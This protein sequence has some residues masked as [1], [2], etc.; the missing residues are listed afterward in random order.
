MLVLSQMPKH[1]WVGT[2]DEA[3]SLLAECMK[4]EYVA[5][6]TET[7]GLNKVKDR[8]VDWSVAFEG[9]R[10]AV[11]GKL[12]PVFK[13][14]FQSSIIKVFQN[15]KF[16]MHALANTGITVSDPIH[17]TL[18]MSRLENTERRDNDLKYLCSDGLFDKS[19]PRHIDYDSPFGGKIKSYRD[20]MSSIGA[21]K[22][23]EYASLDAIS[24][25]FVYE[26][27]RER[28]QEARA[29]SSESLWSFFLR[30]EVPFTRVL[31]NCERRG[32][33][34]DVGYLEEKSKDAV[35]KAKEIE[36]AF[37]QSAGRVINLSSPAQLR[38]FFFDIKGKKPLEYTSGG[39]SG[40]RQPSVNASTLKKW[41][42]MGDPD[43]TLLLEHRKLIKLNGTYLKGL[44]KL[45]DANFRIHTNLNQNGT[46][47][48]RLSS[49][50]P[51]LRHWRL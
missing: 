49:S 18:V 51:N 34:V 3:R 36:Y 45:A 14:L 30:D 33:M 48:G 42:E 19:D 15:S 32:I 25:L 43:A 44:L 29:W 23:R 1:E 6:D 26:E 17:D 37:C 24:L 31:Y 28:L 9:R 8:V 39:V 11:S 41:S 40:N 10:A 2:E 22:A 21:D 7:T 35:E 16:D 46:D 47:T 4:R 5:L 50:E 38:E 12:L 27:L 20:L 13:P